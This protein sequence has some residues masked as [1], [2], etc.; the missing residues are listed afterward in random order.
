MTD[1]KSVFDAIVRNVLRLFGSNYAAV[2][3]RRDQV[4]ELA[5]FGAS[6]ASSGCRRPFQLPSTS[7]P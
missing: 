7:T 2:L 4:F 6:L 5:G 3:L 1:T